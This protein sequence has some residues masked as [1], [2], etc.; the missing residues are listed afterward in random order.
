MEYC[1]G[2]PLVGRRQ[3]TSEE[4]RRLERQAARL[5]QRA[6]AIPVL[7]VSLVAAFALCVPRAQPDP[8]WHQTALAIAAILL[9]APGLALA[10][11]GTRDYVSRSRALRGDLADGVVRRFSD[12]T[13]WFEALPVSRRILAASAPGVAERWETAP[14]WAKVADVPGT[15]DLAREW[16]EPVADD[17]RAGTRALTPEEQEEIR[18]YARRAWRRPLL[19]AV[20]LTLWLCMPLAAFLLGGRC[21]GILSIFQAGWLAVMTVVADIALARG[22]RLSRRLS[23]D[24]DAGMVGVLNADGGEDSAWAEVL[25]HAGLVWTE[26]GT[27]APWRR[28][29]VA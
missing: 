28:A 18:R 24:A 14:E 27:P 10:I 1:L 29:G 13:D 2:M 21:D 19:P 11:L 23:R 8:S 25:P 7:F 5:H 9:T 3:L 17:L 26:E 22:L 6:F 16:L 15:A 20:G 4:R 12:G